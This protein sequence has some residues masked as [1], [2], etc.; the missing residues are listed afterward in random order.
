MLFMLF[1]VIERFRDHDMIPNVG[2]RRCA[3][4][5]SCLAK[6]AADL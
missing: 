5:L 2:L 1:M 3:R 6:R 4:P